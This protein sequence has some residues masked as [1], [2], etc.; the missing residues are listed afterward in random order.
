MFPSV[1]KVNQTAVKENYVMSHLIASNQKPF[2]GGKFIKECLMRSIKIV[3]PDKVNSFQ[4]TSLTQNTVAEYKHDTA[5]NLRI[6]LC[7]ISKHFKV[8]SIARD[9][10]MDINNVA[11]LA[12]F[13]KGCDL[14]IV[15]TEEL[16]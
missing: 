6:Q 13:I 10:S 12:V 8:F 16:S 9:E 14:K 3:C 7:N 2:R 4:N 1:S 5:N 15:S 11:Q